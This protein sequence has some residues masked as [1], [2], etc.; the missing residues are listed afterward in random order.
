MQST[1]GSSDHDEDEGALFAEIDLDGSGTLSF[2]EMNKQLRAG[3]G[4]RLDASL[5]AGGAGE[6]QLSAR[7]KHALRGTLEEQFLMNVRS[8]RSL[9][10]GAAGAEDID[11]IGGRFGGGGE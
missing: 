10:G 11:G 1:P 9:I 8:P 5:Q 7:G 2:G 3:H 6:L 4:V